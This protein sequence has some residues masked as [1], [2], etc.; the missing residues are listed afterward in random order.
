MLFSRSF[1]SS[2]SKSILLSRP[3]A[4][5]AAAAAAAHESKC[6]IEGRLP[7]RRKGEQRESPRNE[8]EISEGAF[9][10]FEKKTPLSPL[11]STSPLLKASSLP[12]L[13]FYS[14]PF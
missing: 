3:G 9:S 5:S 13:S 11:F 8:N 2:F 6:R 14:L 10:L 4:D 7:Q 12:L 1:V